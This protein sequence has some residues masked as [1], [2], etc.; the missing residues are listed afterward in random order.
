MWSFKCFAS[1][2]YF[3]NVEDWLQRITVLSFDEMKVCSMYQYDQKE[4]VGPHKYMQVIMA[5]GLFDKWKQPVYI[6]FDKSMTKEI[7]LATIAALYNNKYNVVACVSDCGGGNQG[8]W[9]QLNI[10]FKKTYFKH[11]LNE[12]NVYMFADVPHI[13]N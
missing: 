11:P 6:G 12:E 7:L 8:L 2:E 13:L 5:R 4:V 9:T 3:W 10:S 1:N